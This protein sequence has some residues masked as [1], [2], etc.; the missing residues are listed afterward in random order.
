M[1][2]ATGRQ[3]VTSMRLML[4]GCSKTKKP[5]PKNPTRADCV[6]PA[7]FY[8]SQLF[9][10][11]VKYADATG[12]RWMVLSARY[13][14]WRQTTLLKPYDM[15]FDELSPADRAAWHIGVANMLVEELWEP[16]NQN[17][18]TGPLL[19]KQMTI[20]IHAGADYC[21]PLAE[22]LRSIGI[23]VELPCEGMGIGEQ[24]AFYTHGKRA[25]PL[26]GADASVR[27][28]G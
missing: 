8:G 10:K 24:L 1:I 5:V 6:L 16:F 2:T 22:I 12:L 17:Q 9:E 23:Q 28:T 3:A 19:P 7:E 15:S 25:N 26:T 21:H 27:L 20:E 11:R 14:I 18:A 13:G 4:I